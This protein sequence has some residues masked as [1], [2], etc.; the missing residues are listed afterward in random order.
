MTF[1]VHTNI[2]R[3]GQ[4]TGLFTTAQV[5]IKAPLTSISSNCRWLGVMTEFTLRS[6]DVQVLVL[7]QGGDWFAVMVDH[8]G[9]TLCEILEDLHRLLNLLGEMVDLTD[10]HQSN[11]FL[12]ERCSM[13]S[14]NLCGM[15]RGGRQKLEGESTM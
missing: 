7:D 13:R 4:G 6:C 8:A 11:L 2:L 1:G 3:P 10:Y 14:W 15:E 9:F 5:V 12:S